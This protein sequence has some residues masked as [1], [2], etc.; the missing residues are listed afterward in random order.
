MCLAFVAAFTMGMS[1][2]SFAATPDTEDVMKVYNVEKGA[3][4]TAY[5]IVKEVKGE[6]KPVDG[7][8]IKDPTNPTANEITAINVNELKAIPLTQGPDGV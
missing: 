6:W 7:V 5:Q 1:T 4:V 8:D 3:T 2:A